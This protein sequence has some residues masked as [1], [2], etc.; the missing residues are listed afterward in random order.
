MTVSHQADGTIFGK[1]TH[2]FC[3]VVPVSS[4]TKAELVYV[5][6]NRWSDGAI[7][8]P[9]KVDH[10]HLFAATGGLEPPPDAG[11][12][13]AG[14]VR[15]HKAPVNHDADGDFGLDLTEQR[16]KVGAMVAAVPPADRWAKLWTFP[17]EIL[18]GVFGREIPE[19]TLVV[20]LRRFRGR[21]SWNGAVCL[22]P[23]FLRVR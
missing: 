18:R 23:F 8:G 13:A 10:L 16:I 1:A 12:L 11:G 2:E 22:W 6:C 20:C 4:S 17:M 7:A 15:T 21:Q 19:A 5:E 9:T 3:K 14:K